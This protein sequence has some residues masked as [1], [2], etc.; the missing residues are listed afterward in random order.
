MVCVLS[1]AGVL[2]L[3][4]ARSRT[5]RAAAG[6]E[7]LRPPGRERSGPVEANPGQGSVTP[8]PQTEVSAYGELKQGWTADEQEKFYSLPQGSFLIPYKWITNLKQASN[9]RPFLADDNV[10]RMGYL[11]RKPDR[12]WNPEG[13]PVGFT[14]EPFLPPP[15]GE[16]ATKWPLMQFLGNRTSVGLSKPQDWFGWTCAACHTA[17][18]ERDGRRIRIDGGPSLG[19]INLFKEGLLES[20]DATLKHQDKFDGF[21]KGVL[22][23]NPTQ[24]DCDD[25]RGQLDVFTS[26][27]RDYVVRNRPDPDPQ[28]QNPHG[29]GRED[30]FGIILNEVYGT[31]LGIPTNYV[32]PLNAPVSFPDLWFTPD[33][34]W[35][36]WNSSGGNPFGRNLTEAIGVFGHVGSIPPPDP[37]KGLASTARGRNLFELE[38]LL[39][40]LDTMA[41]KLKPPVWDERVLGPI[42]RTKS[43]KGKE[44]YQAKCLSCHQEKPPYERTPKNDLGRDFIKIEGTPLG[45]IGTDR[46]MAQ[47]YYNRVVDPGAL[48][49]LMPNTTGTVPSRDF[50]TKAIGVVIVRQYGDLAKSDPANFDPNEY[51]GRRKLG[52]TTP[53]PR[54]LLLAYR[55]RY[56]AGVWASGPYLHNGSVP[57]LYQ[58]LLPAEQRSKTFYLGTREFDTKNVGYK[59]A[60][61]LDDFRK[62]ANNF[63]EFPYD[64]SLSGNSNAGHTGPDY[65]TDWSDE[66]RY[67]VVEYL[68][69]F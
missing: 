21:A 18:I 31:A 68:K 8:S 56:L 50:V 65:G 11:P 17:E 35:V 1:V 63:G 15:P 30:A 39:F 44:L 48:R 5:S 27:Y 57:N 6:D 13:L 46:N 38:N 16:P 10:R 22:G 42:D 2:V 33:A 66:Q 19:D 59:T 55:A 12:K 37:K 20:L 67:W 58:L 53:N 43:A 23:P 60:E 7:A 62:N 3:G 54:D 34:A 61:T 41:P 36:E 25:L 26:A 49:F 52:E 24:A 45:K 9:D 14:K 4:S 51:N 47:N 69:T 28:H 40:D 32:S 64:T 29:F